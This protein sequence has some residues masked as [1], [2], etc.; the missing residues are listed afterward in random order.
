[1]NISF[2]LA[3]FLGLSVLIIYLIIYFISDIKLNIPTR[4]EIQRI[5]KIIEE[6]YDKYPERRGEDKGL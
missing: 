4:Q 5:E 3:L 2:V 1:M 6:Y